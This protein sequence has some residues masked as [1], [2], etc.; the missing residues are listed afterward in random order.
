LALSL[1]AK[2]AAEKAVKRLNK[3]HVTE[4]KQLKN[5]GDNV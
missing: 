1:P 2:E 4:M 3:E 5:P